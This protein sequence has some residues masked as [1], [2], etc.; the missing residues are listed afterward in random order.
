MSS[1]STVPEWKSKLQTAISE[2][3]KKDKDSISVGLK[4][5]YIG[6]S[7]TVAD[8]VHYGFC[9]PAARVLRW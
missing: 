9:F 5:L 7:F 4:L 1:N 3:M 2:N 8:R 6:A